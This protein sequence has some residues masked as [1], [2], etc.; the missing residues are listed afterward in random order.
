MTLI[1]MDPESNWDICPVCRAWM[2][3]DEAQHIT[4]ELMRLRHRNHKAEGRVTTD[5]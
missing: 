5:E 1:E 3:S 4:V 2:E